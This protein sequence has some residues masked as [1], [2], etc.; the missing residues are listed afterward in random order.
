M[1][2]KL[3][4]HEFRNVGRMGAL[5]LIVAACVTALGALYLLSPL[6]GSIIGAGTQ[7]GTAAWDQWGYRS[8]LQQKKDYGKEKR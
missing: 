7:L 8:P 5:L 6:F 4:K 3:F 1:L 2:G